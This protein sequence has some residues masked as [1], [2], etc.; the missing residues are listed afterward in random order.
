MARTKSSEL[1]LALSS[2]VSELVASV[3]RLVDAVRGAAPAGAPVARVPGQR[4]PGKNNP[5]LKAAIKASWERYTPAQ[6]AAR[7]AKMLAGRGLK[8]A[9]AAKAAGKPAKKSKKG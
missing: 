6:R 2:A 9:K 3:S 5:K 7:I 1:S 4:G 8:P